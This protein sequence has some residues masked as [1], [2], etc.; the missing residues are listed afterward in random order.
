MKLSTRSRYGT[1]LL[2][3]LALNHSCNYVLLKDVAKRQSLSEKYLSKLIIPLKSAGF[4]QSARGFK[5]GYTLAK[6]PA[7]I[8]IYEVV[9][10]LEGE[11]NPVECV[12][13]Y[14]ACCNTSWCPTR[15]V[16]ISLTKAIKESLQAVTLKDLVIQYKTKSLEQTLDYCI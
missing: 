12:N 1:R 9:E 3:D 4:V 11:I 10:I 6:D 2:F 5:G 15:D 14:E 16:W 8:S 7:N 13:N